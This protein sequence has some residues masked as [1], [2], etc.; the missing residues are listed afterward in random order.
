MSTY[1]HRAKFAS[2]RFKQPGEGRE[3]GPRILFL[4]GFGQ[5]RHLSMQLRVNQARAALDVLKKAMADC[6][7]YFEKNASAVIDD[8]GDQE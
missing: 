7:T 8:D 5:G 3:E 4:V 2:A 6:D 1:V